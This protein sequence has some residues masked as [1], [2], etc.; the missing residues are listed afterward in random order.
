MFACSSSVSSGGA[1]VLLL[2]RA[3]VVA[4]VLGAA[5]LPA[6]AAS[7]CVL[8]SV[9]VAIGVSAVVVVECPGS[10]VLV[11]GLP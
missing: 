2:P 9:V 5:V 1:R 6:V 7:D 11:P 10:S 8:L 4:E 3:L